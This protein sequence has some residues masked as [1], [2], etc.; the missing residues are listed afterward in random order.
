MSDNDSGFATGGY[1][2]SPEA[3]VA[4]VLSEGAT[5][6]T[7]FGLDPLESAISNAASSASGAD[8][9]TLLILQRH[10]KEL[11]TLQLA[12]LSGAEVAADTYDE[13]K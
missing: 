2:S 1:A 3:Q 10:L 11:C 6:I 13:P 7:G 8:G 12:R 5:F 9:I 4:G